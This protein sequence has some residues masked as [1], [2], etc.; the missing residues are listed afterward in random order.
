M[1][2]QMPAIGDKDGTHRLS[3]YNHFFDTKTYLILHIY[4]Y[5]AINR[6]I[7]HQH[8]NIYLEQLHDK[9]KL[10]LSLTC[11]TQTAHTYFCIAL[12]Y[13]PFEN[14]SKLLHLYLCIACGC[15][16]YKHN[17]IYISARARRSDY[18]HIPYGK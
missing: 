5:F 18:I 6:N 10:T 7:L 12:R 3:H 8:T 1:Q 2:S 15:Q 4:I 17:H 13:L 14:G 9:D 16:S 11:H